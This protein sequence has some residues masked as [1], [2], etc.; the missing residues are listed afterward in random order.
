L[1]VSFIDLSLL[2]FYRLANTELELS[3]TRAESISYASSLGLRDFYYSSDKFWK[4]NTNFKT[5]AKR[6]R[7]RFI[8]NRKN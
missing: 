8:Q 4:K 6:K 7:K 3:L 2:S 5:R 1:P